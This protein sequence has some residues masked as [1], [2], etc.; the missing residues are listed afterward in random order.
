MIS[1]EIIGPTEF[2]QILETLLYNLEKKAKVGRTNKECL[3][4]IA[5]LSPQGMSVWKW[6]RVNYNHAKGKLN[7][8]RTNRGRLS[9]I[10]YIDPVEKLMQKRDRITG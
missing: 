9:I 10:M 5:H 2:G 8:T 3:S 4:C 1:K 7:E 6:N